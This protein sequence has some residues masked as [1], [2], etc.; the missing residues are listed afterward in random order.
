MNFTKH[1]AWIAGGL[2]LL[3]AITFALPPGKARCFD[4][5]GYGN[6]P[7]LEG[8][9]VKPL[10]SVARNSLLVIHSRQGFRYEGRSIGPDEWVL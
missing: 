5:A 3:L 1:L 9:R 6:L 7:I 8:G 10:D 2:A 4:V